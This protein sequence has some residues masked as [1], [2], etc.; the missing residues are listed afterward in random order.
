MA[1]LSLIPD[2]TGQAATTSAKRTALQGTQA[3]ESADY[4]N[5]FRGAIAGQETVPAMYSRIAKET[6]MDT[7]GKTSAALQTQ[8]SNLP[9]TYSKATRG[10]DV[11][12]NQLE[13]LTAQKAAELAP[14]ATAAANQYASAKD[15]ANAL[16]SATQ[17]QQ[18]K[19]L[20]PYTTEQ[21]LLSDRMARETSGFN[22][23][24]ELE[25]NALL[26][27]A[28]MG[29]QLS[30]GEKNRATQLEAAKMGY[31]NQMK[32]AQ[33]EVANRPQTSAGTQMVEV[34]GIKK[35]INS[36]TGQVIATYGSTGSK[37]GGTSSYYSGSW[38]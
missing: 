27:K 34:G 15:V 4:L 18:A 30:E 10:F 25:Y 6:G 38:G 35:L 7:A 21:Q 32:M 13:R 5:R 2:L 11:N 20:T 31:D 12:A 26:Q 22:S 3:G 1:D 24:A 37:S 36:Q 29:I 16:M 23:Q 28:Q 19:E 33:F 17:A 9:Y 8:L 14:T